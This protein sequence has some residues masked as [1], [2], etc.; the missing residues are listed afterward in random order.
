[1]AL[2]Q[3]LSIK[4]TLQLRMTPQ[5]R[6]AIKILQL[7]RP[8]LESMIAGELAQNPVL[9]ELDGPPEGADA[10]SRTGSVEKSETEKSDD[11]AAAKEHDASD[12]S[13]VDW[14]E[15]LERSGS[16][17]H[18]SIGAGS[19]RDDNRARL[20]ENAP[21]PDGGLTEALVDQIHLVPMNEEEQRVCTLIAHNLDED[22]YLEGTLEDL[23]FMAGC[24]L[25]VAN[26]AKE[27]VQELE[28]PGCGSIDLSDCLGVQLRLAGYESDDD[29]VRIAADHLKDLEAQRYG[30]IAKKLSTTVDEV[31]EAHR[32]LRTMDPKPGRSL[33]GNDTRYVSPDAYV[34]QMGDEFEVVLND[35]GLPQLQVSGYYKKLL[36]RGREQLGEAKGYLTEKVR[37]AT[38]LIRSIEQR[39]RTLRK[40]V[41]SIVGFQR[42]F[43]LHGV[44]HLRPMVLKDVANDIG[45]H[46]STVSRAT[47]SKYVHTPQGLFELKYFFTS[48]LRGSDGND[49]SSESVKQRILAI[50]GSESPSKP[51]SDQYISEQLSKENIDIARRTVA[52]YREALGVLPS[53]KRKRTVSLD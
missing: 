43:L 48:S 49:V 35:E 19:D 17:F 29:V 7:A 11:P 18:G 38:W 47:S 45:M 10:D 1:M 9:E 36:G 20:F 34:I 26:D 51:F 4:Q 23:A 22:G 53:S 50:I 6:Q 25:E 37:A 5:L 31:V 12:V 46:E 40:V 30:P 13:Q 14:Q 28:P 21:A 15:Y 16:D 42:E 24:T 33:A 44:D 3:R 39:Q 52:K 41:E 2:E 8:E 32:I 27:I